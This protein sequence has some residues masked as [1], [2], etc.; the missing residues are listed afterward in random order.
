MN[1]D[2]I[3]AIWRILVITHTK[4]GCCNFQKA[5]NELASFVA[6]TERE[7]CA[8][9]CEETRFPDSYTAIRCAEAIRARGE[10]EEP[11]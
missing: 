6:A 5:A 10:Q 4:D 2:K 7:A 11:R 3:H 1:R 8:K 9:L